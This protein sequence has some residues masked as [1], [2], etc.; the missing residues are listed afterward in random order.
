MPILAYEKNPFFSSF[1]S[2]IAYS[3]NY[4]TGGYYK[5]FYNLYEEGYLI[6]NISYSYS[7]NHD[8]NFNAFNVDMVFQWQFAPGSSLNLVWKNSIY[9]ESGEVIKSYSQNFNNTLDANQLNVVSLKVLYY[10]D[11]LYLRKKRG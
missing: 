5:S 9:N 10:F 1:F 4:W 11:Y 7:Q 8:F 2:S 6:D 3:A